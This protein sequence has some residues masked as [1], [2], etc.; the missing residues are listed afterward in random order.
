MTWFKNPFASVPSADGAGFDPSP[1]TIMVGTSKKTKYIKQEYEVKYTG[2]KPIL[3]VCTDEALM[4]MENKKKFNTGNHPVEMLVPMLHFRDA[5]FDFEFATLTGGDVKLEMWAFP[6][7][8]EN[9]K[10]LHAEMKAKMDAPKKISDITS[11]DDYAAIFIPGGHGSMINLPFSADLGKLLHL[12]HKQAM[13]TVTLC[14]GP[15]ALLSTAEG[16]DQEFAYDGYKVMCFTDKTDMQTPMVGYLPGQMPWKCQ[17]SLEKKG[18]TLLNKSETGAVNQDREL[19][20]GDSP[21]AAHN[22]GKFAAPIVAKWAVEH[23]M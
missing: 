6:T 20:T 5:G 15:S 10:K 8:D 21:T 13:P 12:A 23:K 1:F 2:S 16:P 3:V 22:L 4:E 11:L 18:I 19:I 14:H 7:K 9:V 17:E